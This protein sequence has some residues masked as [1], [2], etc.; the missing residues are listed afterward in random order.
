VLKCGRLAFAGGFFPYSDL[1]V[2]SPANRRHGFGV[3]SCI[4]SFY[5]KGGTKFPDKQRASFGSLSKAKMRIVEG[6]LSF[7][8]YGACI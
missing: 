1:V 5:G 6:K 7:Y 4:A 8:V 3:P 2:G